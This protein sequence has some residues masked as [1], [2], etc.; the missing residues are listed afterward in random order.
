[1]ATLL[2]EWSY[3]VKDALGVETTHTIFVNVPDTVTL[4]ALNTSAQG[5]GDVFDGV[6][7]AQITAQHVRV[8]VPLSGNGKATPDAGSEVEKTMLAN[9]SQTSSIYKNGIDV[10]A[11]KSTLITAGRID[12]SNAGLQA[13]VNWLTSAHTGIQAVSKFA[14]TLIALLDALISF[15]KHRKAEG[16]RSI[17][18]P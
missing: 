11:V 12:L 3:Q 5:Y 10:P 18:T 2:T 16:R 13:W 8:V 7:G 9:F 17:V 4:A 6:T 14:L 15:R 1:M